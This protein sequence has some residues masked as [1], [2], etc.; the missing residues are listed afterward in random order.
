MFLCIVYVNER[1]LLYFCC[2]SH[3]FS[4]FH[5]CVLAF[6]MRLPRTIERTDLPL[7]HGLVNTPG[8]STEQYAIR[9]QLEHLLNSFTDVSRTLHPGRPQ[10][11]SGTALCLATTASRAVPVQPFSPQYC[12]S[13]LFQSAARCSS[14]GCPS[15]QLTSHQPNKPDSVRSM[16][17]A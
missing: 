3:Y 9:L 5:V 4:C 16:T 1:I 11:S 7:A 6:F 15:F 2:F 13:A 10:G 14:S 12:S 17:E 8:H